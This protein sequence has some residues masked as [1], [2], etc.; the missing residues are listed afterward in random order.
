MCLYKYEHVWGV[1]T[2]TMFT[3][4]PLQASHAIT[5]FDDED[6]EDDPDYDLEI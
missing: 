5:G 1:Q 3:V 4:G 6:D 2:N